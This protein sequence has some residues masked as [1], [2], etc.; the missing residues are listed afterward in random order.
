MS[1]FDFKLKDVFTTVKEPVE[2]GMTAEQTEDFLMTKIKKEFGP[3]LD[4]LKRL[5][6]KDGK[7]FTVSFGRSPKDQVAV[8]SAAFAIEIAYKPARS[9]FDGEYA[10]YAEPVHGEP[11]PAMK[12]VL[13]LNNDVF[14]ADV[15]DKYFPFHPERTHFTHPFQK[16]TPFEK[17]LKDV[18]RGLNAIAPDRMN[19]IG[20]IAQQKPQAAALSA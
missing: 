5:P 8:N 13:S 6:E 7:K 19:E 1:L 16:S 3:L 10:F 15:T 2:R 9:A 20:D 18:A 12:I 14:G 17:A 11:V 4:K